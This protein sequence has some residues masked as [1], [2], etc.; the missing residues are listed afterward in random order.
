M[1]VKAYGLIVNNGHANK[2]ARRGCQINEITCRV[3]RQQNV[4]ER[5][6]GILFTAL[7]ELFFL[8][9]GLACSSPLPRIL[10]LL[11]LPPFLPPSTFCPLLPVWTLTIR[12]RPGRRVHVRMLHCN[13]WP[14]DGDVSHKRRRG[15]LTVKREPSDESRVMSPTLT[16]R[17]CALWW[18]QIG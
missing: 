15:P 7:L 5:H 11:P 2:A 17:T 9:H 12:T 16:F 3:L 1:W 6:F 10:H 4:N 8:A 18:F 14:R 13:R